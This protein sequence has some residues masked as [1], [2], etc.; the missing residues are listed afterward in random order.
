MKLYNQPHEDKIEF[1]QTT[2]ANGVVWPVFK[3][4]EVY[5]H[6]DPIPVGNIFIPDEEVNMLS[7]DDIYV[8]DETETHLTV[9]VVATG[10]TIKLTKGTP[11]GVT[12]E[13]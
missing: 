3:S 2:D 12:R 13:T 10:Q 6:I 4:K 8:L 5:G 1:D 11:N 9:Q 7:L